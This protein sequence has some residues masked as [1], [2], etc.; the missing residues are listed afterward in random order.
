MCGGR[1]STRFL[2]LAPTGKVGIA[3]VRGGCGCHD[4][5]SGVVGKGSR[6][7]LQGAQHGRPGFPHFHQVDGA[8]PDP[9]I[10][11]RSRGG[12]GTARHN[13]PRNTS[14]F[15]ITH[16]WLCTVTATAISSAVE[17]DRIRLPP[18]RLAL[19][20]YLIPIVRWETP[21]L[22]AMQEKYRT[23]ALDSY[24]AFTANFGT[25]TAFMITLPIL[26][27]CG[28]VQIARAMT[29]VLAAGVFFS[30]FIKD[31]LCLPRPLSPPLQRISHSASAALEYGFPSTHSTN[32]VSVAIYAIYSV[33]NAENPLPPALSYIVQGTFYFYA[34]SIVTGRLYCGMHGYFD[35]IFGSILGAIIAAMQ[36][37]YGDALDRFI[38]NGTFQNVIIATLVVLVLVRIHP[39]PA[40]DC[41]CFDDSV[42]FS[43]V[44]IGEQ[45]GAWHYARTAFSVDTPVPS[46][47]PYDFATMGIVKTTLRILLGV[48]V[49]FAWRG[50]MKPALLRILPPLFRIIESAGLSL[51]RKFFLRA[52]EYKRVPVLRKDDNVIPPMSEIPGMINS[53]RHPRKRAISVGPQSEADAYEAM[54]FRQR[55]RRESQGSIDLG[56]AKSPSAASSSVAV[57][58]PLSPNVE[59]ANGYFARVEPQL[60]SALNANASAES[61][62]T[63]EFNERR[64]AQELDDQKVDQEL[65]LMLQ[66]PRVRYDVEV[67]TKLIVYSDRVGQRARSDVN[68]AISG[69]RGA[70]VRPGFGTKLGQGLERHS[71]NIFLFEPVLPPETGPLQTQCLTG[72]NMCKEIFLAEPWRVAANGPAAGRGF[73]E[74]LAKVARQH[75][76]RLE[77]DAPSV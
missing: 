75:I 48:V 71:G 49:I 16:R 42:A 45:F 29:Q 1:R 64:D 41:P 53:L 69:S 40:D 50:L 37:I 67:V 51:P 14:S 21:V 23:P 54:A 73:N 70:I 65:F 10:I 15:R 27:W 20:D 22:S 4:G 52:S 43:G 39:E 56:L 46:T 7:A 55:K 12:A 57:G 2:A 58:T 9:S 13:Q 25:H 19:R 34:V 5:N 3:G 44:F 68:V 38:L 60:L 36:C 63:K 59:E 31:L 6:A 62:G 26:F 77:A 74:P 24:F 76:V 61:G 18:W 17:P 8:S 35:V 33:Y 32:A 66:K 72:D 28:Q 47:A 11:L 30:G